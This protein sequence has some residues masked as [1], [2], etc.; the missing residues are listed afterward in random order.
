M[1]YFFKN[2]IYVML[3]RADE[4]HMESGTIKNVY[5]APNHNTGI[6]TL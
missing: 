2:E 1:H 4:Q 6:K 3:Q 5:I